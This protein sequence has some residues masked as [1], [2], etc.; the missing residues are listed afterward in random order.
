MMGVSLYTV[1]VVLDTLGV[2]DYGLYNVIGGVV[3]MFSFL[4]GTMS[5]ASQ[6]FFA[7]ELGRKNYGGLK[8]IFSMTMLIYIIIAFLILLLAETIGLWFLN[9]KMVIPPDRLVA[10]H[11]VFQFSI[12]SFMMTMFTI[13]YNAVIIARERM[14]VYAYVSILEAILKLLIVYLLVLFSLDKLKLYAILMFGV[15]SLITLIYR[16]Y[17]I[18]KFEE[19]KFS[20]YWEKKLFK[21]IVGYSGW[22]LFGALATVVNNQGI[23]IILNLFF[24]P[25][26]NTA[27]AIAF[28]ISSTI[29][30]FVLN[31][32]TASRPQITKYYATDEKEKMLELVAQTSKFSFILLFV[33]SMPFLLETPF[34]LKIWLKEV[35]NHVV[36]FARLIIVGALID[37]LSYPLMTAAQA[38]GKVKIYQSVVGSIMLLV[39][40]ISYILFSL[41]YPPEYVFYISILSSAVSLL[42]RLILLKRMVG[43]KVGSFLK[44]VIFKLILVVIASYVVPFFLLLRLEEGFSRFVLSVSI[45]LL[46]SVVAIYI[47]GLTKEESRVFIEFLKRKRNVKKNSKAVA[48]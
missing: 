22:N 14:G 20:F 18:R 23:N 12:L 8:R 30:Q 46:F 15:T 9:N 2:V 4:S 11:W 39:L 45:G 36:H 44:K 19:C 34:V 40:P 17:C 47:F 43:L 31:F 32:M 29:N 41:G 35:P 38:T 3:I 37:S 13:P 5:G 10:A 28:R 6:R 33:L 24:G 1:R 26:V 7:F 25:V 27:R 21:E 48:A 42:F 16:F